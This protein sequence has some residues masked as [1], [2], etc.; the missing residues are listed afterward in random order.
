[1]R[2]GEQVA[3]IGNPLGQ[4]ANAMTV[5]YIGALNR[6][7][8]IDGTYFNKIQTDAALNRGNSGGPLLNTLGEV[9]G[10]VSAKTMGADVEGL[11]FAIPASHAEGIVEH[12]I[13]YGFVRGRAVLGVSV[14]INTRGEVQLAA[15]AADS[16]A[17]HAGLRVGDVVLA[18]NGLPV[19]SFAE[20]RR[21]LDAASPGDEMA[22]R[23]RRGG[24]EET[25]TAVLGEYKPVH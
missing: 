18:A 17:Y 21:M 7:V 19:P 15:V 20:L 24:E 1:V 12:L 6:D 8:H 22:L 23:V 25:L 16:A 4:M 9:V 2:V 11:G 5:G 13:S 14:A 10:V 3:A